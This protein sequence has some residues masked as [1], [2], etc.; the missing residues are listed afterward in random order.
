M[1]ALIRPGMVKEQVAPHTATLLAVGCGTAAASVCAVGLF[2]IEGLLGGVWS[3]AALGLVMV[4]AWRVPRPPHVLQ[5][6]GASHVL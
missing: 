6:E 4:G 2:H 5:A 1:S 3:V